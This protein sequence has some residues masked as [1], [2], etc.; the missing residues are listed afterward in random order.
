MAR[1]SKKVESKGQPPL[2][3]YRAEVLGDVT[4]QQRFER[5]NTEDIIENEAETLAAEINAYMD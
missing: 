4:N 5:R 1:Q 2:H 3:S